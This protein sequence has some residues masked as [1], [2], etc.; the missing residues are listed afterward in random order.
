MRD[1]TLL[2]TVVA[3][4]FAQGTLRLLPIGLSANVLRDVCRNLC[5]HPV[6]DRVLREMYPDLPTPERGF[7]DGGG[8]GLAVRPVG[9]VR[10]AGAEGDTQVALAD[11]EAVLVQWELA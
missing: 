5:G 9:G 10:G 6:T 11:L 2:S 7:W 1:I 8:I 3:P 4:R